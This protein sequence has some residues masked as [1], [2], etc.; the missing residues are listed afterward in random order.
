MVELAF[1][2]ILIIVIVAGLAIIIYPIFKHG[3]KK[4][5]PPPPPAYDNHVKYT[6]VSA[7][8]PESDNKTDEKLRTYKVYT[9]TP[10]AH[11]SHW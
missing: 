1:Q 5:P 3:E 7:N 8:T 6:K 11:I 9:I 4:D 10:N 2:F